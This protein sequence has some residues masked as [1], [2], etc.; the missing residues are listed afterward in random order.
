[1]TYGEKEAYRNGL[2]QGIVECAGML[3]RI[4]D[5]TEKKIAAG[6][7]ADA[8]TRAQLK[9]TLEVYRDVAARLERLL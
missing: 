9:M 5:S 8:E 3:R 6:I 2:R 7:V 1:M 4:A